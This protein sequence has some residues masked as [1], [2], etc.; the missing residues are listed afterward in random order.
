[1]LRLEGRGAVDQLAGGNPVRPD[2]S[3][4]APDGAHSWLEGEAKGAGEGGGAQVAVVESDHLEEGAGYLQGRTLDRD[5]LCTSP[6]TPRPV[7]SAADGLVPRHLGA[8]GT[9]DLHHGPHVG[10]AG[11]EPGGEAGAGEGRTAQTG[12]HQ[13][14]AVDPPLH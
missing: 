1:M 10:L 14:H 9:G 5:T 12:H 6:V 11:V 13:P 2:A 8:R 7:I 4:P 3:Q